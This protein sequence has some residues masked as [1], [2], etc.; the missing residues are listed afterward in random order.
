MGRHLVAARVPRCSATSRECLC[1]TA[2]RE[3]CSASRACDI[4]C[5]T[6]LRAGLRAS[7][8]GALGP[9]RARARARARAL[10]C[11]GRRPRDPLLHIRNATIVLSILWGI[12]RFLVGWTVYLHATT[13]Q[14]WQGNCASRFKREKVRAA[15]APF[16]RALP[17][18]RRR[19]SCV[20]IVGAAYAPLQPPRPPPPR[21]AA[22]PV[23]GV[24]CETREL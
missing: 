9:S 10:S 22:A 15:R 1:A 2:G 6:R 18:L 13:T 24:R 16:V 7:G 23:G 19:V 20:F 8:S 3:S 17:R 4:A 12:G 5:V 14:F 11:A 21:D